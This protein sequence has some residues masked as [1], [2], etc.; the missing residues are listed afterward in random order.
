MVQTDKAPAQGA[1]SV[2]RRHII[3]ST[4]RP[5]LIV[6]RGITGPRLRHAAC[7]AISRPT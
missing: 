6:K 1:L 5:Y 3:T 7:T 2:C 4:R